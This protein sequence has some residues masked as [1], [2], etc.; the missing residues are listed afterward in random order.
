MHLSI[1]LWLHIYLLHRQHPVVK[2][3]E[4]VLMIIVVSALLLYKSVLKI[5]TDT[6]RCFGM[7]SLDPQ[8]QSLTEFHMVNCFIFNYFCKVGCIVLIYFRGVSLVLKF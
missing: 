3:T 6:W 4:L 1:L 7:T 2:N 5:K 8:A